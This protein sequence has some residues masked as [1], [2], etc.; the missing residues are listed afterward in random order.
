MTRTVLAVM[1]AWWSVGALAQPTRL[2]SPDVAVPLSA[3]AREVVAAIPN[4]DTPP[5]EEHYYRSNE[6]RHDLL[7]S[8]LAGRGGAYVGVGSDQNYTMAAMAG[9]EILFL[10]DYD[11]WMSFVHRTYGVLV[12]VSETPEALLARFRE[13]A[14]EDTVRL[15][16]EHLHGDP[17]VDRLVQRFRGLRS[18]W[19]R[20][21]DRVRARGVRDGV[22]F[23]WLSNPSMYAHVRALFLSGRVIA[24]SGD[25]TAERTMRAVGDAARRLGTTVRV[26]YLSNAE[27]FFEY[28]PVFIANLQNLPTDARSVI[29]RTIRLR[30]I[31]SASP[32][33]WHYVVHEV[34]DFLARLG[35][36]VYLRAGALA[37]DLVPSAG[38]NGVSVMGPTVPR[39]FVQ[40]LQETV[41]SPDRDGQGGHGGRHRRQP[42][43]P[44]TPQK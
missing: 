20:Y 34:P 3:E 26:V 6:W 27:Q 35:T 33:D 7:S 18:R 15:L 41:R 9:S 1:C 14:E 36:G 8:P 28:T 17:D 2:L 29:V 12:P 40:R 39:R 38:R 31:A 32:D 44:P 42:D 37:Y 25:V 11:P 5:S 23:T 4:E 22:G 21:L 13:R 10:V 43:S 30:R 19:V 24:R 16:R